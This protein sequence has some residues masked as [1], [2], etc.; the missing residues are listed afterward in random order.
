MITTEE[1][2]GYLPYK[3]KCLVKDAGGKEQV[4]ELSS[5]YLN[6]KDLIANCG[7]YDLVESEHGFES[8]KP[9]L[10]PLSSLTTEQEIEGKM[11][12]PIVELARISD[13]DI[14]WKVV[15]GE[16]KGMRFKNNYRNS[17][18]YGE[19]GHEMKFQVKN[20]DF[21]VRWETGAMCANNQLQLFQWLYKHHF[22]LHGLID[23][24][25]AVDKST[26]NK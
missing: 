4:A 25:L 2:A 7:F 23:R 19:Y 14:A 24:G 10:R 18:K 16:V 26:F 11:V 21:E 6:D 8:V 12:V 20:C 5:I 1:I 15:D 13:N 22:D 3:V 9:L 17:G